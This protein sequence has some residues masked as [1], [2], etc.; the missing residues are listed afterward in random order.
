M[1]RVHIRVVFALKGHSFCQSDGLRLW[2]M[3]ESY[4][5]R[6]LFWQKGS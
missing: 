3:I 2:V 4:E 6:S 1:A 5:R